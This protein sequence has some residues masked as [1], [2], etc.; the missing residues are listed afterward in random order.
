MLLFHLPKLSHKCYIERSSPRKHHISDP[1]PLHLAHQQLWI[2]LWRCPPQLC[3]VK[4]K[5]QPTI[6]HRR[7]PTLTLLGIRIGPNDPHDF[8]FRSRLQDSSSPPC[9]FSCLRGFRHQ[10]D[11]NHID[12]DLL[13]CVLQHWLLLRATLLPRQLLLRRF[14]SIPLRANFAR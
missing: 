14:R 3:H 11:H 4:S 6:S 7:E 5:R 9:P 8:P 2:G 13:E 12:R 10:N 1:G